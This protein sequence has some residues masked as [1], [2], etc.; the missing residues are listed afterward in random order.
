MRVYK[1]VETYYHFSIEDKIMSEKELMGIA[2]KNIKSYF[3]FHDVVIEN[4][5]NSFYAEVQSLLNGKGVAFFGKD[6]VSAEGVAV[7]LENSGEVFSLPHSLI[8]ND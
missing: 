1:S 2:I 7:V 8:P 5:G 6:S 4:E 3:L